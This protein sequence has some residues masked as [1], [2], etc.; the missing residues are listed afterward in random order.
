MKERKKAIKG[1]CG[2]LGFN[3]QQGAL[4]D[5]VGHTLE[6]LHQEEQGSLFIYQLLIIIRSAF[7]SINLQQSH[8]AEPLE[9]YTTVF[10]VELGKDSPWRTTTTNTTSTRESTGQGPGSKTT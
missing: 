4:G 7:R 9:V 5:S 1:E 2:Q 8:A 6:L 3:P 10:P